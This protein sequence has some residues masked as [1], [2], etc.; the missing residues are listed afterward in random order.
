M[1]KM[2]KE[3][4]IDFMNAMKESE[5]KAII[6]AF[7]LDVVLETMKEKIASHATEKESQAVIDAK[8]MVP[9]KKWHKAYN[10]EYSDDIRAITENVVNSIPGMKLKP[11]ERAGNKAHYVNNPFFADFIVEQTGNGE[12]LRDILLLLKGANWDSDHGVTRLKMEMLY[13][14]IVL[15]QGRHDDVIKAIAEILRDYDLTNIRVKANEDDRYRHHLD[16]DEK[17]I[18]WFED[19]VC[20]KIAATPRFMRAA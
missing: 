7:G 17:V 19:T 9:L 4:A 11:E 10:P 16:L 20:E 18:M 1:M 2:T 5:L 8:E 12:V 15:H 6:A 14:T 13:H 3:T